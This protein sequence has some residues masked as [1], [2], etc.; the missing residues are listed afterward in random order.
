VLDDHVSEVGFP[1]VPALRIDLGP[2]MAWLAGC[3]RED[4]TTFVLMLRPAAFLS[5][6]RNTLALGNKTKWPFEEP[7]QSVQYWTTSTRT[8]QRGADPT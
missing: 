4:S 2:R 7:F 1:G 5:I 6:P 8:H 3:N